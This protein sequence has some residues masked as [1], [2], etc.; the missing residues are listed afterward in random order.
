MDCSGLVQKTCAD[1]GI[2]LPRTADEQ[3]HNGSDVSS[4]ANAQPG[5]LLFF[6]NPAYHVA[7]YAGN[8]KIIESPEPGKTVHETTIY[9][10]PTSI[11]RIVSD[12]SAV[13]SG[14]G[15]AAAR[16]VAAGLNP[17]VAAYADRFAAAER[18]NNLPSGLLAAVAQQES[19]GNAGATS[20]AGARG[21]MQ[22]MP[23]TAAG[24]GV[25]PL[26][27]AQSITAAAHILSR[28]LTRYHG[29]V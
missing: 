6:G 15:T 7:I 23:A 25:D 8:N 1:L 24:L 2:T 22:L 5:D 14:G 27:P 26:D 9:Q 16:L 4:L 18:S 20:P 11:R 3:S 13:T 17:S 12:S 28:N 29:S 10:T 21:L 19:G